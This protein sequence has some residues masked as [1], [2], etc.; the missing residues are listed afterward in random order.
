MTMVTNPLTISFWLWLA[1]GEPFGEEILLW[2]NFV[3]RTQEELQTAT[4]DWNAQRSFGEVK[5]SPSP[6][7]VSPDIGAIKLRKS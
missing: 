5:G 1:C 6:R 3:A 2:W 4:A 7:L